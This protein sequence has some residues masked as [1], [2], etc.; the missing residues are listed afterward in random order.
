M[1][2]PWTILK[3]VG[4]TLP[5]ILIVRVA[6]LCQIKIS[7]RVGAEADGEYVVQCVFDPTEKNN[8]N[9]LYVPK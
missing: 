4:P 9:P 3:P 6:K 2:C 5:F 7:N 8:I 1:S